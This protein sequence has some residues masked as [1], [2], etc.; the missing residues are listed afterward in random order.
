M[1]K[2]LASPVALEE[3]VL[4][5]WKEKQVFERSLEQSKG[6]PRW[7]FY[8]GPPT[9]NGTPHNGHVLTRVMKD[10]FP[11]FKTMQ[12]FHVDRKAGWD[13]HGLPVEV[14]VEKALGLSG[15]EEIKEY[16]LEPFARACVDSV[17]TYVK[18][19]EELTTQIGF[20]VDL[21]EAYVTYHKSYVE[22]VW[23]A[24]ARLH[25]K[26][27]LYQGHKVVWWWPQGGTALSAGEVGLGY[28][29]VTDPAI[30][31][32]FRDVEDP[33]VSYLAWTT[34]PWTLPSNVAL[35]VG[36]E[37][38]YA[39]CPDPSGEGEVVVAVALAASFG[40]NPSRTVK[41]RDLV[42]RRYTP[43]FDF[44]PAEGGDAMVIVTADHV[45]TSA[46]TG[47][48][49]TAP[50][51]GEDDM[52]VAKKHGLGILQWI[53][54]AGR[55][56]PGTGALEGQFCKDADKGIIADLEARG[57]LF[58]RDSV[59]HDYP[60]CWRADQDPL[61]QYAR[62]GWF[63]RTTSGVDQALENNQAVNWLPGHI[64]DGRFGDFL[65]NNVD[66]ALSR[67]RFWGTPLNI[68]VCDD[69][70]HRVAPTSLQD[71]LD[72]DPEGYDPDID[73]DLQ[74]HRPWV[75]KLS[76]KCEKCGGTMHRVPE[77]IDC[78]FD[79]GCM[80]FAQH[81][82]P[83]KNQ[84]RFAQS[85]PADYIS[86][87]VDQT[88]GWFYSLLMISTL[89][90]DDQTCEEYG[91]DAVGFPRP[92]KNCVVLGHV[93]DKN[94]KKESKSKGNY[95]S[96]NLVLRGKAKVGVVLD[97]GL[98]RGTMG[99]LKEQLMSLDLPK[100]TLI[101]VSP[102]GEDT[103]LSLSPVRAKVKGKEVVHLHPDDAAALGVGTGEKVCFHMHEQPPGADAFRWLFCA[104]N[105]P[106][107]NT[108]LS[109]RAIREGQREFLIRLRNI[110]QFFT[111]YADI[112][113]EKGYM[114]LAAG[115]PRPPAQRAELDRWVLHQL[116]ATTREVT[117]HLEGYRL[118]EASR[119]LLSFVDDL[120][121]WY[122]RRSRARF[123]SEDADAQDALWT[124]YEVLLQTS[125]L[126]APFVPFTA[127]AMYG[128]LVGS[129]EVS[130]HLAGW[131]QVDEG[132][133]DPALAEE[134]R[135]ARAVASL[136]L[137]ARAQSKIKVRQPLEE[138]TVVLAD[139]AGT[140]AIE[141]HAA[142][143]ADEL[144]VHRIVLAQDA[145]TFV[146]YKL[147]PDFKKLGPKLGKDVKRLA[148]LLAG[149]DGA[150]VKAALDAGGYTVDLG[151]RQVVVTADELVVSVTPKGEWQS[152]AAPEAVVAISA[153]LTEALLAEGL[154]RELT[155]R[156]QSTR[157][158]LDLGYTQ[159]ISLV[160]DSDDLVTEALLHY[161]AH[162][163]HETLA[164]EMRVGT[165]PHEP[166][167]LREWE[168]EGHQVRAWIL[169]R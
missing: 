159:R 156:V 141:R 97:D 144:N 50:A 68:W 46:G 25:D 38:E 162:L 143:I 10:V 60:F 21:D 112:A 70:D 31:V 13:T 109:L 119:A 74:V 47:I 81:G 67:E 69:C 167:E 79:S 49:H 99:M 44:G 127:E 76:F 101:E 88:R 110:H 102:V 2:R 5:F 83:H 61:I 24:L 92:Y 118:Y 64:K 39:Y 28:K 135:L 139:A 77:V 17:F 11:R 15:R 169:P 93:T 124:L 152:A 123:W 90:F 71:I 27:L 75:D 54:P 14:E 168:V 19:W 115:A 125:L 153:T 30:T 155:N 120:S 149:E 80:P 158:E 16:G 108:R 52:V 117:G 148:G 48:V 164:A 3:E 96:P 51:F 53:D 145:S 106:W 131:P 59:R 157:K 45:T 32:R 133:L 140:A 1:F 20:W 165:L 126:I 132:L 104:S 142:M 7:V 87:A 100:D 154:V 56:V 62:P 134:M 29:E 41:G 89:L 166:G 113:V 121:N 107:N 33:S 136:G 55:F 91:L 111:I 122:V 137:A 42:G 6:R 63:I 129:D 130:V 116:H 8:E 57:V 150:K 36:D 34:T 146:E 94:G 12:G 58:Q 78:W 147:K 4:R 65:R 151:D 43:I 40:L 26:G 103:G 105:P 98:A 138:A 95:T 128:S 23:W 161:G 114:D 35:A 22:S 37:V 66:W 160:I 82:F 18:E 73:P 85:F 86:E 163:A 84:Q 72:R 9:A